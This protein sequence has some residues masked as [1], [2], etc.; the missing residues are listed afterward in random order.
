M[1][2]VKVVV[3]KFTQANCKKPP[4]NYIIDYRLYR[5]LY[6]FSEHPTIKNKSQAVSTLL[7]YF[8]D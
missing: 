4:D 1:I 2:E 3:Y 6:E 8:T 5:F 7:L